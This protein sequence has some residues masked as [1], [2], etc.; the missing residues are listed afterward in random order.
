MH[1][2]KWV[3]KYIYYARNISTYFRKEP[4]QGKQTEKLGGGVDIFKFKFII[5]DNQNF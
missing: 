4:S 1:A 3:L 5:P 2:E